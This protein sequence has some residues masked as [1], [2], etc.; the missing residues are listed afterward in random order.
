MIKRLYILFAVIYS[1][2]KKGVSCDNWS[3][4]EHR[5]VKCPACKHA[6]VDLSCTRPGISGPKK[7]RSGQTLQ[8]T[9]NGA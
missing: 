7:Y 9:T 8:I 5:L 1:G 4:W 2:Q 3:L 6:E